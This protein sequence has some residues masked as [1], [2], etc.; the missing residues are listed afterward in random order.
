MNIIETIS[1]ANSVLPPFKVKIRLLDKDEKIQAGDL[2]LFGS[3]S[4]D[5]HSWTSI[6]GRSKMIG[7]TSGVF[8]GKFGRKI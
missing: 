4:C 8:L 3:N 1:R 7:E 5:Y 2:Y 6:D